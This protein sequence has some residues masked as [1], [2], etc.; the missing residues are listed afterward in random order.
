MAGRVEEK[1]KSKEEMLYRKGFQLFLKRGFAKTTVSDIAKSSGLAKGTFYLY[2]KNKYELRD[3]LIVRESKRVLMD[4]WNNLQK[5]PVE[6]F[7]N[8][9]FSI[10]DYIIDYLGKN[11]LILKFINKNLTWGIFEQALAESDPRQAEEI[12]DK[13]LGMMEESKVR[14]ERPDLMMFTIFELVSSTT[15]SCIL[16]EKPVRMEEYLPYLHKSIHQIMLVYTD[17]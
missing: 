10:I 16:S 5:H 15:Y 9:M 3:R 11:P 6:G 8:K 14:C 13:L 4:A 7:E 17:L 12:L 1:K 2:F